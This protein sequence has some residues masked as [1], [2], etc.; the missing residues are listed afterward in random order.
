MDQCQF[1]RRSTKAGAHTPATLFSLVLVLS[2]SSVAQR[3][4]GRIPRR[5]SRRGEPF[6]ALIR[7]STKA[8][9]HTPATPAP[10]RTQRTPCEFAQRRPGRIPRRH[11]KGLTLPTVAPIPAQRRPGRIPRRHKPAGQHFLFRGIR[12]TKAGA[13]TPAT[14]PTRRRSKSTRRSLNE[15]RGAYPGDTQSRIP[16]RQSHSALNEGRGAYPG[17]TPLGLIK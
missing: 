14:R 1:P 7:R 12:S 10:K 4:P 5:H 9:A 2:A 16:S 15:G 13:H 6:E 17:D 3:R 8:G 11:L